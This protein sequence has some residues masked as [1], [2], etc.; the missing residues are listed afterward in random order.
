MKL[1]HQPHYSG[2]QQEGSVRDYRERFEAL[3]LRSVTLPGQGF[4]EMFLQG[5]QPSLQTAVRELKP[6]GIAE[7]MSL[8]LV[9][10]KLD[11]VKKKKEVINELEELEQDSYTLRQGMEQLVIDLTRNKG[12]RFYGFILDHKVVVAIDSGATDNF[13]LVELAFSLKL[14]TSITNQASV[15]LGQRRCIQSVGTCLGIRLWVQE[16]EITENFLLLDLA[17]TDVDVIL[18]YEWLSKM[19]ETMVNWQNQDF[20]FSH[21]QQW[22]TLCAEDEE[23]EQVTTKVKMKSENEQEDIEEQR[24]N[25]GEMLVVSYLEDKVTL[26]GESKVTC[27][28]IAKEI[29]G[30]HVKSVES[31]ELKLSPEHLEEVSWLEPWKD[32]KENDDEKS[33]FGQPGV[34]YS[35]VIAGSTRNMSTKSEKGQTAPCVLK[36]HT[37]QTKE[38][39]ISK[40]VRTA[41]PFEVVGLYHPLKTV[42]SRL[43]IEFGKEVTQ[44][45][46]EEMVDKWE[47][48]VK[49]KV[50]AVGSTEVRTLVQGI[51]FLPP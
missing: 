16:V 14:P 42:V 39:V 28:G 29:Q 36:V 48:S 47:S 44:M 21:N 22:I 41:E 3:C 11:V 8:T 15:L 10:A 1:N 30:G 6:N 45:H 31:Q 20:S 18:G 25:D 13:I 23:L 7:L 40:E 32:T 37:E 34:K 2:I 33:F 19:G 4:E 51:H 38:A 5:L 27:G 12:M 43:M 26:K 49:K 24:N 9:Q 35:E 46:V 50:A 17:K